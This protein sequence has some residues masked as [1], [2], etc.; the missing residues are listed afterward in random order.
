MSGHE[1]SSLVEDPRV[2]DASACHTDAV[3]AGVLE[4]AEDVSNF[5]DVSAAKDDSVVISA[6]EISEKWPF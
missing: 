4:H 1:L 2:S 5:K 3:Y 6:R